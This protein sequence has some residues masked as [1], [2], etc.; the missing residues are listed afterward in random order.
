MLAKTLLSLTLTAAIS[1]SAFAAAGAT[2][3]RLHYKWS[4]R[5]ALSWIARAAFPVSG[6]GVLETTSGASVTSK[7]TVGDGKTNASIFYESLMTPNGE[8]T[9]SSV[10]GY[11]WRDRDRQQYVTFDYLRSLANVEKRSEEGRERKVRKLTSSEPKDVLTAIYYIRQ[12]VAN[13]TTARRTEIYSGGKP[14]AFIISPRPATSLQIAKKT[15][16]VRPFVIEPIDKK[17]E[18]RVRVWFSDDARN[19][20]VQIEIERDHATLLLSATNV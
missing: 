9:L 5:G 20:P 7:L 14:Y 13:F 1:S 12:N 6:I 16:R 2:T 3:E 4:L 19:L 15:V 18:G 8:R 11:K 10:D 17:Q